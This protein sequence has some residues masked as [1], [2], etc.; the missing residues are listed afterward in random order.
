[1][2]DHHRGDIATA[3]SSNGGDDGDN[4]NNILMGRFIR[5]FAFRYSCSR[6]PVPVRIFERKKI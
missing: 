3:A 4:N 1:M 6:R 5:V 2:S